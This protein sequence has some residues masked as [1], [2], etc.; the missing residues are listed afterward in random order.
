[1]IDY[2]KW[3]DFTCTVTMV[4]LDTAAAADMEADLY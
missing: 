2:S 4:T 3:R 1:M